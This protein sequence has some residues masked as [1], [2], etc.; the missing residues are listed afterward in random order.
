MKKVLIEDSN[1]DFPRSSCGMTT[2]EELGLSAPLGKQKRPGRLLPGQTFSYI[3]RSKLSVN[4][5][6]NFINRLAFFMKLGDPQGLLLTKLS[7]S[8]MPF[9]EAAQQ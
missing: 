6:F 8:A 3:L 4:G 5:F 7:T 9:S 1:L 2:K